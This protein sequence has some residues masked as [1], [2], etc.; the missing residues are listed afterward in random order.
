MEQVLAVVEDEEHVPVLEM[1]HQ[2]FAHRPAGGFLNPQRARH[3]LRHEPR[4]TQR[5]ELDQPDAVGKIFADFGG[6]LERQPALADAADA[7]QRE[8]A[9]VGEEL[10]HL[11]H[12]GIAPDERGEL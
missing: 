11:R 7:E 6:E 9:R 8:Q 1:A 2:R 4:V 5:G 10:R 12:L 3:R